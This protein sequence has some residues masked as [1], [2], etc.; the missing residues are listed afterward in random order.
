MC[1]AG[2]QI[3]CIDCPDKGGN[4]VSLGMRLRPKGISN[5]AVFVVVRCC[6]YRP[7]SRHHKGHRLRE[8]VNNGKL[9][10]PGDFFHTECTW[11][12]LL[13]FLS[14]ARSDQAVAKEGHEERHDGCTPYRGGH[15]TAGE[16]V[17]KK[18]H[19]RAWL[20]QQQSLSLSVCV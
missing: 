12:N 18:I 2:K 20:T 6:C 4:G 1:V 8:E 7:P 13:C 15:Q 11:L 19:T 14:P 3:S 5:I 16:R 17:S 10:L 9:T